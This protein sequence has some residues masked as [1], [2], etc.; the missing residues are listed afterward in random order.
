V[1]TAITAL[2]CEASPV[3]AGQPEYSAGYPGCLTHNSPLH[4]WRWSKGLV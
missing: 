4:C 3:G 2:L 1:Y